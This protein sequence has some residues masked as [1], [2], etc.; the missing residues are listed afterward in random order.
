MPC[1]NSVDLPLGNRSC[2]YPLRLPGRTTQRPSLSGLASAHDTLEGAGR[3]ERTGNPG[4]G[5]CVPNR[6]NTVRYLNG[7]LDA[8]EDTYRCGLGGARVSGFAGASS[9]WRA[10]SAARSKDAHTPTRPPPCR[11]HPGILAGLYI[12]GLRLAVPFL[13]TTDVPLTLWPVLPSQG[14][15]L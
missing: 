14:L 9:N 13:T 1:S 10:P 5:Q 15:G 7:P 12:P 4:G 8:R 6:E 3:R 11:P 2:R